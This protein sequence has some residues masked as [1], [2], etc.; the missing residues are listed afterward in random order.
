MRY[1]DFIIKNFQ[2]KAFIQDL[3]NEIGEGWCEDAVLRNFI[4]YNDLEYQLNYLK[5]FK[6]DIS[7]KINEYE[8]IYNS[9][10]KKILLDFFKKNNPINKK[11]IDKNFVKKSIFNLSGL[12][13]DFSVKENQIFDTTYEIKGAIKQL[14]AEGILFQRI[15]ISRTVLFI[16]KDFIFIK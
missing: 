5:L 15:N 3:K 1:I 13:F 14:V 11:T 9:N 7:K 12:E 16:S 10:A 2:A 4:D 6:G 8:K